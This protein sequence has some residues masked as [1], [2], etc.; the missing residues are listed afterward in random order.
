MMK[1]YYKQTIK[2]IKDHEKIIHTIVYFLM[3]YE[4]LYKE[5]IENIINGHIEI[6]GENPNLQVHVDYLSPFES[7]LLKV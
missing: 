2:I 5:D 3:K 1:D 6:V 7:G 4:T